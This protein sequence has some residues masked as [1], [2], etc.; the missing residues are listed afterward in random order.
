MDEKWS[1]G[2]RKAAGRMAGEDGGVCEGEREPP[3]SPPPPVLQMGN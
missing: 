1:N 2:G 3:S